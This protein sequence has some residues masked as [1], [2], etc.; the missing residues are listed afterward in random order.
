MDGGK[1]MGRMQGT[2]GTVMSIDGLLADA[3]GT[4]TVLV[5]KW[6]LVKW[7]LGLRK[8]TEQA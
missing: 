1:P 3:Y 6:I 5:R 2:S 4:N 7:A 8:A